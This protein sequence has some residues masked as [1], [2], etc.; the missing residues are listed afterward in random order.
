MFGLWCGLSCGYPALQEQEKTLAA[1][2]TATQAAK[3]KVVANSI[4]IN[5]GVGTSSG[6]PVRHITSHR[7]RIRITC[8]LTH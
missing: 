3:N 1:L 6:A 2:I 4:A 8:L 5:G 7:I